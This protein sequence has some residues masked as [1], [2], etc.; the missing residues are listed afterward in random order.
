MIHG[1]REIASGPI[2]VRAI[3]SDARGSVIL[4]LLKSFGNGSFVRLDEP[5]V[6]PRNRHD[7]N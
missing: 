7:R 6:T 5:F 1:D 2:S 4:K 3:H